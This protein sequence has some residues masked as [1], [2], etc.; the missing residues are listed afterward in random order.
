MRRALFVVK[1]PTVTGATITKQFLA[2]PQ[3]IVILGVEVV[4]LE[5]VKFMSAI[6]LI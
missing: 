3:V 4:A 2:L 6:F 1:I 5:I